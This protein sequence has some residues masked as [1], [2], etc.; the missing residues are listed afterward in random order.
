M[1]RAYVAGPYRGPTW[2]DVER[3]IHEAREI[4]VALWQMGFSALCPHLNT[5]HFDGLAP[6]EVW[7]EG[8]LEWLRVSDLVVMHPRWRQSDGA[9]RER[10]EANSLLIPVYYWPEDQ[11]ALEACARSSTTTT[12]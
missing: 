2:N 11:E 12:S 4:A 6:D 8:D 10:Q 9:T 5:A 7:L 1:K 3:N